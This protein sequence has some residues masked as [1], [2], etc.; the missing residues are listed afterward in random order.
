MIWIV[1]LVLDN[2][3]TYFFHMLGG[4]NIELIYAMINF[5]KKDDLGVT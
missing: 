1:V 2:I 4:D 5:S 3:I